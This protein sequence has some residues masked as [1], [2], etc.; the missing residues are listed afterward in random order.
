MQPA[1]ILLQADALRIEV[2][3]QETGPCIDLDLDQ[4]E[5]CR[6]EADGIGHPGCA[7]QPPLQIVG[8][9]MIRAHDTATVSLALQEPCAAMS[10]RIDEGADLAVL[11][12]DGEYRNF[13]YRERKK[14]A[15]L[16]KVVLAS[17]DVPTFHE[18]VGDFELV[19]LTRRVALRRQRL[20]FEQRTPDAFVGFGGQQV[21]R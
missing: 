11:G 2:H 1:E 15:G 4:A 3:E 8:P 20:G 9:G 13:D 6:I 16:L 17:D 19:E 5:V 18:D 21:H 12:L 14:V 10:A 7:A